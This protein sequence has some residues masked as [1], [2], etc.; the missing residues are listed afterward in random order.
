MGG[1]GRLARF[2]GADLGTHKGCPYGGL[3]GLE[4]PG[5]TKLCRLGT[6][7]EYRHQ[8]GEGC[9]WPGALRGRSPR[10]REGLIGPTAQL[11]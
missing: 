10:T 1:L 9:C 2:R 6:C 4:G 11:Q 5:L 7:Y 3:V 8:V